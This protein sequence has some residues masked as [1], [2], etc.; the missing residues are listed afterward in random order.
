MATDRGALKRPEGPDSMRWSAAIAGYEVFSIA[1][2]SE[3][4]LAD[5][6][7]QA[8]VMPR[9]GPGILGYLSSTIWARLLGVD[10]ERG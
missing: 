9:S 10:R 6:G 3:S 5:S 8:G 7:L 4:G 2:R 1:E